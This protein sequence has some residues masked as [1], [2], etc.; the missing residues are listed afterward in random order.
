MIVNIRRAFFYSLLFTFTLLF[1]CTHKRYPQTSTGSKNAVVAE[2]NPYFLFI[3]DIHLDITQ[4]ITDSTTDT[5]LDLWNSFKI[6]IDSILGSSNPPS[7]VICTGDLSGHDDCDGKCYLKGAQLQ[8]RIAELNTTLTDLRTL[9]SKHKIPLFFAPGNNDAVAGDYY[10]FTSDKGQTPFTFAPDPQ[11]PYPALNV[12][13]TGTT[14]PSLLSMPHPSMGY[15]SALALPGLRV[16]ALNSV[17]FSNKYKAIDSVSQIDAGNEEMKWLAGQLKDAA[18]QQQ[19]VYIAMHIPPGI[20]AYKFSRHK[21]PSTTWAVLPSA[22]NSWL[23]IFLN[24]SA[25]YQ[26]TIAGEFYGHTHMDE[27]RLLYDSTGKNI[28]EVAIS[29]PGICPQHGNNPGFKTVSF[30]PQTMDITDFTTY[31]TTLPVMNQWGNNIYSFS[32]IFNNKAGLSIKDFIKTQNLQAVTKGIN[33]IYTVMHGNPA[34][35]IS[36]GITVKAQ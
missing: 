29:T 34:Y 20:D 3:S 14:A 19:K 36:G 5:G 31:Y 25:E 30:N 26:T 8:K 10:S 12:S 32:S 21:M 7:F 4:K 11:N 13:A 6:K 28:T 33:Q 23:K 9:V 15:Y 2:G 22:E 24:L 1:S 17:I 16:I 35:D 27:L 18:A